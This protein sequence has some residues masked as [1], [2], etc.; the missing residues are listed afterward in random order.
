LHA[1]DEPLRFLGEI[2]LARD[3]D[4]RSRPDELQIGGAHHAAGN[5][6]AAGNL[7]SKC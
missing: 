3:V 5:P 6:H 2:G 1:H 4:L 7:I